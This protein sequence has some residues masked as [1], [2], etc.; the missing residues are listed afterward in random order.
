MP[1]PSNDIETLKLTL[2]IAG[3]VIA[4]LLGLV[5][6]FLNKQITI[7]EVL[8]KAVNNLTT[9]VRLIEQ[10]QT[11]TDPI[12]NRRLNDHALRIDAHD[13][14]LAIIETRCSLTHSDY[15]KNDKT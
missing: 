9:A 6:Y 4:A 10:H 12:I 7:Q 5:A 14:K 11:I 15:N 2:W 1:Q 8:A 3:S 13:K